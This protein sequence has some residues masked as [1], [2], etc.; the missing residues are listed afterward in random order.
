MIQLVFYRTDIVQQRVIGIGQLQCVVVEVSL[1]SMMK[2]AVLLGFSLRADC[3]C[4]GVQILL[5]CPYTTSQQ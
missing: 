2:M 3:G 5:C 1:L 4:S